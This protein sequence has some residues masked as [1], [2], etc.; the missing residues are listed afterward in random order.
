[1]GALIISQGR[2]L[3]TKAPAIAQG[4]NLAGSAGQWAGPSLKT[5]FPKM[6]EKY[7][8]A[9]K[10]GALRGGGVFVWSQSTPMIYNIAVHARPNTPVH[11]DWF[12][13]G[14]DFTLWDAV[15]RGHRQVAL[16][17]LNQEVVGIPFGDVEPI[18]AGM[19]A[20]GACDIILRVRR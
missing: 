20:G 3:D 16:P 18:L 9:A 15:K 8:S 11:L 7:R 12:E 13:N 10:S 5:H 2:L 4:V 6:F 1:M 14:L 17:M 19:A